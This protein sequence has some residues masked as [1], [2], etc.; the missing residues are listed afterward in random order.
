MKR[1]RYDE[2]PVI[3]EYRENYRSAGVTLATA[4]GLFLGWLAAC[5]VGPSDAS[6]IAAGFLGWSCATFF[7]LSLL[8][9]TY[10]F[11][12]LRLVATRL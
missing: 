8:Q 4:V 9:Y 6:Q 2:D 12:Y 5:F 3:N 7:V 10:A 1:N 11:L